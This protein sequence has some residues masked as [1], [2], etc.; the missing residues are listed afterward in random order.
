MK[1]FFTLFAASTLMVAAHAQTYFQDDFEGGSLTGNNAWITYVVA[2]PD[3]TGLD[4]NYGTVG[5][6]YARCSNYDGVN[7]VLNTWLISPVIDLSGATAPTMSFDMTKRYAGDDIVVHLSTDYA[8]SGDPGLA[9][10]TDITSLFTLD[11]NTASWTFVPSGDGDLSAYSPNATSYIAFEY[12]GSGTDGST[13]E[14]DNILIQEG[15]TVI[16]TLSIYDIQYT[17]AMP[18][19]SPEMGNDVTTHGVVTAIALAGGGSGQGYFI[20]DA[21]GAWNGIMVVDATNTPSVGDSVE[22]TG[23]VEE[24]FSFTRIN[25]VSAFTNHGLPTTYTPADVTITAAEASSMEEYES[26]FVTVT[27]A[28]CTND[29]AGFGLWV[30]HDGTDTLVVDDDCFDNSGTLGTWYDIS[31]IMSFSFGQYKI[32]PR[33][34]ADIVVVGVSGIEETANEVTIYPNPAVDNVVINTAPGSIVNIYSMTGA[35]VATGVSNKTIDVSEL[36]AGLYQVVITT[37]GT[38]ITN[39]LMIK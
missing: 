17:T 31:G 10:W 29:N 33:T 36:E 25:N 12:I 4:W 20:Q 19:D 1:K 27:S 14:V 38:Q 30:A 3:V 11:A 23:T 34:G 24:N 35:L 13:W 21:D 5:G 32:N 16:P 37:N 15:P 7:H 6:N 39:K 9:T 26:V 8:G 18:A 2:D 22:V 28:E